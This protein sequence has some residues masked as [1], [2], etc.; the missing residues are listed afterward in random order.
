MPEGRGGGAWFEMTF[1]DEYVHVGLGLGVGFVFD[2]DTP[3]VWLVGCYSW[4]VS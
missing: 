2:K 1:S 4:L 3:S